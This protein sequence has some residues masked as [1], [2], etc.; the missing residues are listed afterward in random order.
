MTKFELAFQ[1]TTSFEILYAERMNPKNVVPKNTHTEI[2]VDNE[3]TRPLV[4]SE[5]SRST[6]KSS[7]QNVSVSASGTKMITNEEILHIYTHYLK[8]G[9]CLKQIS[10]TFRSHIFNLIKERAMKEASEMDSG[11]VS[12]ASLEA[13]TAYVNAVNEIRQQTQQSFYATIGK[14]RMDEKAADEKNVNFDKMDNE[15]KQSF[16]KTSLAKIALPVNETKYVVNPLLSPA[17][18]KFRNPTTVANV[19]TRHDN[20]SGISNQRLKDRKLNNSG[21]MPR[22]PPVKVPDKSMGGKKAVRRNLE[23]V[24]D[25]KPASKDT[26]MD[27]LIHSIL[28]PPVNMENIP[29]ELRCRAVSHD[30]PVKILMN[31]DS[32]RSKKSIESPRENEKARARELDK[33]PK[34]PVKKRTNKKDLDFSEILDYESIKNQGSKRI[35]MS[36]KTICKMVSTSMTLPEDFDT[37]PDYFLRTWATNSIIDSPLTRILIKEK[38]LNL[39][40]EPGI[41]IPYNGCVNV[42]SSE[43]A[44]ENDNWK[45]IITDFI[46]AK[47]D[48]AENRK[49]NSTRKGKYRDREKDEDELLKR[50]KDGAMPSVSGKMKNIKTGAGR[51][52]STVKD[53]VSKQNSKVR[54]VTKLDSCRQRFCLLEQFSSVVLQRRYRMLLPILT[55]KQSALVLVWCGILCV[56]FALGYWI[57]RRIMTEFGR[58]NRKIFIFPTGDNVLYEPASPGYTRPL[59]G[60]KLSQICF[61]MLITVDF[62]TVWFVPMCEKEVQF[63]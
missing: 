34:V 19:C 53:S 23:N 12:R 6:G 8:S 30:T 4:E 22:I 58:K 49:S 14:D 29:E 41:I 47:A 39:E 35:Q 45:S 15:K 1:S 27:E 57:S 43:D 9:T 40:D 13:T 28:N 10:A 2:Q 51:G 63:D 38:K 16:S 50:L 48:R 31:K 62:A 36:R 55:C 54:S 46:P 26:D 20:L 56:C 18:E 5:L 42:M 17:S 3:P 33:I 44:A 37:L 11:S 24:T 59:L 61:L 7:S 60:V 21:S 52:K 32:H 25:R